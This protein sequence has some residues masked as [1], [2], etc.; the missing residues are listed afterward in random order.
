MVGFGII[1]SN[2][3]D[4]TGDTIGGI[5]SGIDIKSGTWKAS[6][7]GTFT[8]TFVVVPDRGFNVY[9]PLLMRIRPCELMSEK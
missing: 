7:N 3:K 8:G 1:P 5:G 2:A 6:G 4:S 9:V